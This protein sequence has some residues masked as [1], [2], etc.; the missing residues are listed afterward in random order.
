[1]SKPRQKG[2][3]GQA[4]FRSSDDRTGAVWMGLLLAVTTLA[5]YW[6]VSGH[7]FVDYD[8]QAY[9]TENGYVLRGI[10]WDG[11]CWAFTNL[12]AGFWQ[13]LTWLSHMLDCQ[14]Y[15]LR[16]GGHHLTNL[17]LHLGNTVLLF[18]LLRRMTGALWRSAM[19]AALFALHPL[20]VESVAW[21]AERKDVLSTFFGFLSLIFYVRYAERVRAR[22]RGQGAGGKNAYFLL[23]IPYFLSFLF[24]VCGL[25][26]KT[27]V[28]TLPVVMLLLDWWPLERVSR[29]KIQDSSSGTL[30]MHD[31]RA[32][33]FDLRLLWRLVR[34]K[35]PFFGASL[36]CGLL[37]VYAEKGVGALST[38]AALPIR[39]RVAN[40]VVSCVRYLEQTVWPRDMAVF[41][42][43]PKWIGSG[44]V[45]AALVIV[46]VSWMAMG[47]GWR[48]RYVAVG[49]LWYVVTW[50]PV[51]G[52]IPVGAHSRADRYTYVPLI[53]VFIVVVWGGCE[54]LARWRVPKVVTGAIV[55][56]ILAACLVQT[57]H[58]LAYWQDTGKLF[59]HAL[60]VTEENDVAH[61]SLGT[62]LIERGDIDEAVG[63]FRAALQINPESADS[64]NNLGVVLSRKGQAEQAMA[65]FRRAIEINPN[66]VQALNNLG[67]ELATKGQYTEAIACYQTALR[68]RPDQ[69]DIHVNLGN[70]F[71][72]LD[73]TDDAIRQYRESLRFAPDSPEAH[74]NLGRAL[75]MRGE[76][77]EAIFHFS[78]AVRANPDFAGAH[79]NLGNAYALQGRRQ[80]AIAQFREALRLEP[81][82]VEA[83]QQLR[84][85]GVQTLE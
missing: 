39:S 36:L 10:T 32:S 25:M 56:V 40:V 68:S 13:P 21:V 70:A 30:A 37:T 63:H 20:H 43:Y 22:S 76:L 16:A 80:E 17:L 81:D 85:L 15:G 34:E 11:M 12:Q 53:G 57:R 77:D 69:A 14:L 74:N 35:A 78:E 73:N 31:A 1:M 38:A 61:N 41:Y 54:V 46:V 59:R 72:A 2:P 64:Y 45:V 9:V 24:F 62:D 51:S 44:S 33:T 8:D 19:V 55:G 18:A 60:A 27:M 29:F 50:L 4:R 42:P 82:L 75:A 67:H 48:R 47:M 83:K 65:S 28:V 23:L 49:W 26:S 79:F 71:M 84:A 66:H 7:K 5:V 6:P 52:L 3:N 58:Q